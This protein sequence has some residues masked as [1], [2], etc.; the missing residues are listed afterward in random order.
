MQGNKAVG[1]YFPPVRDMFDNLATC[2]EEFLLWFHR[3]GWDYK[4]KSGQDALERHCARST[5]RARARPAAM[6]TT[7]QSLAGR[8]DPAAPQ[9][10]RRHGW[11][12]RSPTP[13]S[14][15][16]RSLQYFQGFSGRPLVRSQTG[17]KQTPRGDPPS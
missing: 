14:G 17:N 4:L 8:I 13:R 10:S 16:T 9:G 2:P 5:T 12:S 6:Q 7:W 11:R 3:C 1:Q 15:A